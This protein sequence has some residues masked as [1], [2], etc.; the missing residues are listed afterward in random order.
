MHIR[1]TITVIMDMKYQIRMFMIDGINLDERVVNWNDRVFFGKT[2][3]HPENT[4]NGFSVFETESKVWDGQPL[5]GAAKIWSK[6]DAM[7]LWPILIFFACF[8]LT[9]PEKRMPK[10]SKIASSS[11]GMDIVEKNA[12]KVYG[13]SGGGP[14]PG[15]QTQMPKL[16]P[17]ESY[18][19]MNETIPLFDKVMK[20]QINQFS[21]N[22]LVIALLLYQRAMEEDD[23]LK[24]FLDLVTVLESM[25]NDG[26]G[27]V[28]FKIRQRT[29]N[30][31][32]KSFDDRKEIF[33][34][35]KEVYNARSKLVHGGDLT[36]DRYSE[37][38]DLKSYLIPIVQKC[39]LKFIEETS[40]GKT[41]K[42]INEELDEMALNSL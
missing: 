12:A 9:N 14:K 32:G 4:I 40:Q 41:K 27:E 22:P 37:Y 13:N 21:I 20:N 35:M 10:I 34:K 16:S 33:E 30:F 36:L 24:D 8:H 2:K 29:S 11:F 5:E 42:Q 23:H 6:E 3:I 15:M 18:Q 25:F 28:T 38:H 19:C 39:L 17:D 1:L 26:K 31:S 7:G